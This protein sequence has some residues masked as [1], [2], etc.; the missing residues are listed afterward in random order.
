MNEFRSKLLVNGT[1]PYGTEYWYSSA[2]TGEEIDAA[3]MRMRSMG[4]NTVRIFTHSCEDTPDRYDYTK[5]DLLFK[6]AV[7]HGLFLCPTFTLSLPAWRMRRLGIDPNWGIPLPYHLD[8]P[9]YRA[10]LQ[11]GLQRLVQRYA[12][13]PALWAWILWN[14]P[15]RRSVFPPPPPVWRAFQAWITGKYHSPGELNQ[16]WFQSNGQDLI[17]SFSEIV[18]GMIT[19]VW[20]G[21]WQTEASGAYRCLVPPVVLK[22]ASHLLPSSWDAFPIVK[23]WLEYNVQALTDSIRWLGDLVRQ[24]DSHHPT[25]INPDGFLQNQ[26]SS[27]RDLGAL[28][29]AVDI[30]GASLH[31]GHHFSY[32]DVVEQVPEAIAFYTQSITDIARGR[33]AIITELQAGPNTWSGNRNFTPDSNDLV[34]WT[35]TALAAGLKGVIYWLWSPRESGWEAGEWGLVNSNG[36]VTPRT[37]GA[38]LLG[39]FFEE[40]SN[41]LVDLK[42]RPAQ[43]AILRSPPSESLGWI[44][45]IY[46]THPVDRYQTL[47][48]YGCFRALWHAGIPVRFLSPA[49]IEKG[50][51]PDLKCLFIPF[52]EAFT[53]EAAEAVFEYVH[54]GGWVYAE[55]PLATKDP[56]G[57]A[58]ATRPGFGL[59]RL[60]R[61]AV[62]FWPAGKEPVLDTPHGPIHTELFLQPLESGVHEVVAELSEGYD[63]IIERSVGKGRTLFVGTCLTL[64][65]GK[66]PQAPA[67]EALLIDFAQRSGARSWK[68]AKSCDQCAV[69]FLEGPSDD[70]VFILNYGLDE[71]DFEIHL[72]KTYRNPQALL[73]RTT[74]RIVHRTLRLVLPPRS[75]EVIRLSPF[76]PRP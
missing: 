3:F 39:R 58:C 30:F 34:L 72:P 53:T 43:V 45:S 62:D 56:G 32:I 19:P 1:L 52:N 5:L 24:Y 10:E 11:P 51:P 29:N 18:P 13:H 66:Q 71:Q 48:E 76:T 75:A 54:S 41:W 63:V 7:E 20:S 74:P 38:A 40:H 6:A 60:F 31:P 33:P 68:T 55:T 73:G 64:F 28:A 46:G 8:D 25:H 22:S 15:A 44:E 65:C 50:F 4:M 57:R 70:G 67:E 49:E 42:Q 23:D 16:V 21:L 27:G 35:V 61:Q 14:E 12:D 2:T 59:D 69:Y 37:L 17:E 47:A 9:R 26:V 36:T